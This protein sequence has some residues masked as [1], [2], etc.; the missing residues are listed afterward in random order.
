M[1]FFYA[2]IISKELRRLRIAFTISE[3]VENS[4]EIIEECKKRGKI[5]II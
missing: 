2:F 4:N 3:K 1:R 5:V